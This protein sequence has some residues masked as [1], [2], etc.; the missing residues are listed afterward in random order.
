VRG[1]GPGNVDANTHERTARPAWLRLRHLAGAGVSSEERGGPG[2]TARQIQE[3]GTDSVRSWPAHPPGVLGDDAQGAGGH[4]RRS[5]P[6]FPVKV[7]ERTRHFFGV[8]A[9]SRPGMAP[10]IVGRVQGVAQSTH[11][12]MFKLAVLLF[13]PALTDTHQHGGHQLH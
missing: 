6:F 8:E 5:S 10:R 7:T 11:L 1:L 2:E 12:V 9:P 4:G 3:Q 13:A